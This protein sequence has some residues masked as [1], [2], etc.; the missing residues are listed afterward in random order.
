MNKINYKLLI[1][2]III[3]LI[4]GGIGTLLGNPSNY[5]IINKPSFSPPAFIFPIVWTI[6]YILMGISAY[7]IM[8]SDNKDK[9]KAYGIYLV[10]L[11]VNG[12][13]SLFFFRFKWYLFSFLWIILLISLVIIMIDKFYK[14]NKIAGYLQLPYLL[15]LIF[16]SILNLSIYLLN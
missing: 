6:L 8:I 3:P 1:L 10:Q 14:I 5:S 12:L 15:W 7:M 13:W 11:I 2:N 9:N 16:A 4:I